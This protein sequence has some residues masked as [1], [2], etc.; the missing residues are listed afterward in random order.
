MRKFA[1]GIGLLCSVLM[2]SLGFYASYRYDASHQ[3]KEDEQTLE[4]ENPL[5]SS[6]HIGIHEGKVIVRLDDGSTY[7]TTD[8]SWDS[9]PETVKNEIEDGYILESQ[10]ELYSF[11]ENYS[12]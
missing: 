6:Y 3:I 4:V 10:Q 12:S 9:L 5:R 11:L 2:I 7:E 8:I 1:Y